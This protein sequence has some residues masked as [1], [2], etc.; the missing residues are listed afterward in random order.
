MDITINGLDSAVKDMRD[1]AKRLPLAAY[2][3]LN[4]TGN[5]IVRNLRNVMKNVLDRPTPFILNA[6]EKKFYGAARGTAYQG[7]LMLT[8]WIDPYNRAALRALRPEIFGGERA[9]KNSELYLRNA[10]ILPPGKYIAAARGAWLDQYGNIPGPEM[11]RI[12][13]DARLFPETGYKMNRAAVKKARYFVMKR[14]GVPIGIY[15]STWGRG[16]MP[17]VMFV[18]KPGYRP[19]LD[20]FGIAHSTA[21][22]TF[23]KNFARMTA[24]G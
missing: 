4:V 20:F 16:I 13:A 8:M 24:N 3:A 6:F 23:G 15:E 19:R 2:N 17:V 22:A 1:R 7:D 12:L 10:G 11:V 14:A 5:D 18:S 9:L 21:M